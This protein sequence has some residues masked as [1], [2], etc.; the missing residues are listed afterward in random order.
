L[1]IKIYLLPHL[2]QSVIVRDE[3]VLQRKNGAIKLV[4]TYLTHKKYE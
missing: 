1:L 2:N 4:S 3:N